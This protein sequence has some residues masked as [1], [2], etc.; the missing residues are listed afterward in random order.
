MSTFVGNPAFNKHINRL[1]FC[2]LQL[3]PFQNLFS[4]TIPTFILVND[5][6]FDD[7]MRVVCLQ[8]DSYDHYPE[9]YAIMFGHC[10]P[11]TFTDISACL[12]CA[13]ELVKQ[14]LAEFG[15]PSAGIDRTPALNFAIRNI[16]RR[17]VYYEKI[18]QFF[19]DRSV[20]FPVNT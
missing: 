15:A 8:M 3:Y 17:D 2:C 19:C 16:C 9:D 12:Y 13:L 5:K 18:G 11:S 4:I 7:D 10:D 20:C 1:H 14:H 6:V